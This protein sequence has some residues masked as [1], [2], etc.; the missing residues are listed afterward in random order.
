MNRLPTKTQGSNWCQTSHQQQWMWEDD[1]ARPSRFWHK[2]SFNL[3]ALP[4]QMINHMSGQ[5]KDTLSHSKKDL[6][7]LTPSYPFLGRYLEDERKQR[8]EKDVR[9]GPLR[10][11]AVKTNPKVTQF[12]SSREHMTQM[13]AEDKAWGGLPTEKGTPS[14]RTP[15]TGSTT[16]RMW[17]YE[18]TRISI[19]LFCE[20]EIKVH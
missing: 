20:Q 17:K 18:D 3:N 7:N 6:E 16:A 11:W 19:L 8:K 9:F 10:G 1:G 15:H 12:S 5:N 2:V 4:R 14:K 13:G